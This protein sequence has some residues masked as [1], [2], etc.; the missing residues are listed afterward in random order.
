MENVTEMVTRIVPASVCTPEQY[1]I[2]CELFKNKLPPELGTLEQD[3]KNRVQKARV[4][5]DKIKGGDKI[6]SISALCPENQD[7]SAISLKKD[8]VKQY[9]D[10]IRSIF[11][12]VL[13]TFTQEAS[14]LN[15]KIGEEK[16]LIRKNGSEVFDRCYLF[17]YVMKQQNNLEA[18]QI[19]KS[20]GHLP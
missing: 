10:S 9:T 20:V 8:I 14:I 6:Y 4:L 5:L 7:D 16:N 2:R 11:S 19:T 18:K 1:Q 3:T 15:T 12:S 13:G 17:L